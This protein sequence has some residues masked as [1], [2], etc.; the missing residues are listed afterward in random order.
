[1]SYLGLGEKPSGEWGEEYPDIMGTRERLLD[2][3]LEL[4]EQTAEWKQEQDR[5]KVE[6]EK[7]KQAEKLEKI[8]LIGGISLFSLGFYLILLK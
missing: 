3:S 5:E 6:E 8:M 4:S 2:E 7:R 1:V